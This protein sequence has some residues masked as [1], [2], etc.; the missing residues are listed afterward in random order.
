MRKDEIVSQILVIALILT[1]SIIGG[2][3]INPLVAMLGVIMA[4]TSGMV[5]GLEYRA[6]HE[7]QDF[8]ETMNQGEIKGANQIA[9]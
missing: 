8:Q 3:L 2:Y 1:F 7:E 9:A 4:A 6:Y 5:T